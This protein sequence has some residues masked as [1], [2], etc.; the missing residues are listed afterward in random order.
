MH[1]MAH[2]DRCRTA[3]DAL[4][5]K[6]D[7]KPAVPPQTDIAGAL[8]RKD[9]PNIKFWTKKEWTAR[10]QPSAT[11]TGGTRGKA[12]SGLG[13]NV[14][15]QYAELEDG[16]VVDGHVASSIRRC[17]RASWVH[18]ANVGNLPS[19]WRSASS[20]TLRT[21]HEEMYRR[22]PYLQYCD[23]NWKVE[24]IAMDNYPSWY[25]TWRSKNPSE[26]HV[27]DEEIEEPPTAVKCPND[28][29]S[30][31]VTKRPKTSP[32]L[33]SVGTE[34]HNTL[35]NLATPPSLNFPVRLLF[36]V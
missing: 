36:I 30:D 22:F 34:V 15:M 18:L 1:L 4:L 33:V 8:D 29:I 6:I 12:R 23:D 16:T 14:T 27:K 28:T 31:L 32:Q 5:D 25:S 3:Y 2:R 35:Q 9:Y 13:I 10:D 26:T 20:A 7:C 17:A 11:T 24:Q 21:Y 19:R